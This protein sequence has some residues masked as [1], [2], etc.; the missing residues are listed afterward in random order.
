MV[1][2]CRKRVEG[3]AG[4]CEV[5]KDCSTILS[6]CSEGSKCQGDHLV[7]CPSAAKCC[8]YFL[9]NEWMNAFATSPVFVMSWH[10]AALGRCWAGCG[11]EH[12][13]QS[14]EMAEGGCRGFPTLVR[15]RRK[16]TQALS[17]NK[18]P[19]KLQSQR[20]IL[21]FLHSKVIVNSL[22]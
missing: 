1:L 21:P 12:V 6:D 18:N 16:G 17:I 3:G 4:S 8:V 2:R 20:S 9:H 19:A 15:F 11:V 5:T 22:D 14:A 7:E 10:Y 13:M